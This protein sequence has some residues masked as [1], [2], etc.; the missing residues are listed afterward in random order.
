MKINRKKLIII[1]I[2]TFALILIISAVIYFARSP[3]LLVTEQSFISLYGIE[4]FRND[5]NRVSFS[6]FRQVKI[7]EVANDAGDD[8]VQFAVSDVCEKPFC[9]FFPRRFARSANFYSEQNPGIRVAVLEGKYPEPSSLNADNE[10]FFNY[11]TDLESDFYKAG[12]VAAIFADNLNGNIAVLIE[13]E[14]NSA[15]GFIAREAVLRGISDHC[16]A[17]KVPVHE[18]F[19]YTNSAGI[20]ENAEISCVVI[21]GTGWEF[22]DK[23][24]NIPVIMF[25]WLDPFVVPSDVVMVIDDS[26]AAQIRQAAAF[27]SAGKT[28]ERIPSK[29]YVFNRSFYD[30]GI[31]LKIKKI[32]RNAKLTP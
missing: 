9:V 27:I 15:Y 5:I 8:I 10:N 22:L 7:V 32:G 21:A 20:P 3:A 29:F 19:F 11:R 1:I 2:V 28:D 24:K 4:R 23:R 6:L 16:L 14:Q 12:I 25:T 13:P 26:P 31:F 30:R 18:A 17:S